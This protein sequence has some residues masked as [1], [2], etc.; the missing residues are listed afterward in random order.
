MNRTTIRYIE[1]EKVFRFMV[2][3]PGGFI[4]V[5]DLTPAESIEFIREF[6]RESD[7]VFIDDDR[8]NF[9]LTI[10]QGGA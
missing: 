8:P 10:I 6:K 1:T 5:F 7:G 2:K 9:R 4:R 3:Q